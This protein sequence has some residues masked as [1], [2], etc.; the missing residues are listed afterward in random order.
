MSFEV[1]GFWFRSLRGKD[2]WLMISCNGD[3]GRVGGDG[4]YVCMSKT[5]LLVGYTRC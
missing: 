4:G 5:N 2:G 1:M 3:E